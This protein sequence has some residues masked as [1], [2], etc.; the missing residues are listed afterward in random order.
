M[1]YFGTSLTATT[2]QQRTWR[3][4]GKVTGRL[5][6]DNEQVLNSRS[7]GALKRRLQWENRYF[8]WNSSVDSSD[9]TL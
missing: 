8:N 6:A 5:K 2:G 7:L 4:S 1:T 9:S 3:E